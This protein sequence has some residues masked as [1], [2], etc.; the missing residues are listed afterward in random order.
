MDSKQK[1]DG[2]TSL[3]ED[4]EAGS[5]NTLASFALA[6]ACLL[7]LAMDN[8]TVLDIC[9]SPWTKERDLHVLRMDVSVKATLPLH[10]KRFFGD[11]LGVL[12]STQFWYC[13][14]PPPPPLQMPLTS[15]GY[16]L[17]WPTG[18]WLEFPVTLSLDFKCQ[19]QVQIVT[20]TSAWL[21]ISQRFPWPPPWVQLIC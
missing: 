19:L 1:R 2:A 11:Q 10:Q 5:K 20:C 7:T 13:V 18:Y 6:W 8:E 16:H 14:Y 12:H 17:F 4:P 21:A 9:K 15:P 3:H